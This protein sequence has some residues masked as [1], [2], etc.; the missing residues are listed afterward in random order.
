VVFRRKPGDT[1]DAPHIEGNS[2]LE[3][4]WTIIP[5][6]TVLVFSVLGSRSLAETQA[7]GESVMEV[8]VI[9]SQWS[10]RLST[11][12]RESFPVSCACR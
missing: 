3:V 11:L 9:G 6:I 7:I 4:T 2:R 1:T 8:N 10:W 5:L 12:K